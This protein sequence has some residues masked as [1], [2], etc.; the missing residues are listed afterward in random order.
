VMARTAGGDAALA[1]VKAVDG[2]Y[3]LVGQV[4]LSPPAP[5][6]DVLGEKGGFY[7]SAADP[8]LLGRLGLK[9]G[10]RL[11]LGDAMVEVRAVLDGEPD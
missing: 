10:D 1:E 5:L 3:P 8:V 2:R 4:T 11:L 7:G 9:V 6:A